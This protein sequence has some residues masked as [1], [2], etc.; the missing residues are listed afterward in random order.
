MTLNIESMMK[1]TIKDPSQFNYY[2][3]EDLAIANQFVFAIEGFA[4][5][6]ISKIKSLIFRIIVNYS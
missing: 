3:Y 5:S 1:K 6:Y 2:P 4:C